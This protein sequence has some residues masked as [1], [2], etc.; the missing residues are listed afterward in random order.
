MLMECGSELRGGTV[1]GLNR[2]QGY[3]REG[4]THMLQSAGRG[5]L[6]VSLSGRTGAIRCSYCQ[7]RLRR[8]VAPHSNG[9]L[10]VWLQFSFPSRAPVQRRRLV[11]WN[12]VLNRT[13]P[14]NSPPPSPPDYDQTYSTII[15]SLAARLIVLVPASSRLT[16]GFQTSGV[17]QW[18]RRS[19]GPVIIPLMSSHQQEAGPGQ[20]C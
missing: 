14:L 3:K 16:R 19:E 17:S 6:A 12:P 13:A 10:N 11:F 9:P 15:N 5:G 4:Q 20:M 8:K 1:L 18:R 7:N 2:R